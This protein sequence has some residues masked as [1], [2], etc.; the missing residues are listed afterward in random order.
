[1]GAVSATGGWGG[2]AK[3]TPGLARKLAEDGLEEILVA[4]D[5]LL[6]RYLAIDVVNEQTGEIYAEAGDEITETLL[7]QVEAG[8]IPELPVLSI[9][10]TSIGPYI[11]TTRLIDKNAPHDDAL[12][13]IYR[14]LRP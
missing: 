4:R 7:D 10:H 6:G 11:L 13:A 14:L 5:E 9:D 12:I 3:M 8:K 1:M 2:G